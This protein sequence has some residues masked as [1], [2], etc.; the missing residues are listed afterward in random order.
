MA[1]SR[2]GSKAAGFRNGSEPQNQGS[3]R[4]GSVAGKRV[5]TA[6]SRRD[7][8]RHY[9]DSYKFQSSDGGRAE[10]LGRMPADEGAR[11]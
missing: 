9:A 1:L 10:H 8:S 4:G 7:A 2:R 5:E 11:L 6:L 3:S